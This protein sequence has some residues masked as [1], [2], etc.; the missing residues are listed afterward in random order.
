MGG[1]DVVCTDYDSLTL[2]LARYNAKL[3]GCSSLSFRLLD[4]YKPDIEGAFDLVVGSEV[5]Y[6]EKSF[7]PLLSV[8]RQYTRTDGQVVLSD[9]HRPQMKA[10]LELSLITTKP[11]TGFCLVSFT[12]FSFT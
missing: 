5:V 6:F 11:F 3:N 9:Q 2:T 4:W 10:F 12:P 8:I 7:R 1:A